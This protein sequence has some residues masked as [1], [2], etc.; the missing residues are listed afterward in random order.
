MGSR[1]T[2]YKFYLRAVLAAVL[3]AAAVVS[4]CLANPFGFVLC[5]VLA[6]AMAWG[7]YRSR[8]DGE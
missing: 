5:G 7:A 6:A 2:N 4:L 1:P 3:G 8:G